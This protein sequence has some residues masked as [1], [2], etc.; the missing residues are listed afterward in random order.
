[1]AASTMHAPLR[2]AANVVLTFKGVDGGLTAFLDHARAEG[3]SAQVATAKLAALTVL[4]DDPAI[5]VDRRT[6]A[7]WMDGVS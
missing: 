2:H 4:D 6:V 7:R 1:M 3:W 5:V